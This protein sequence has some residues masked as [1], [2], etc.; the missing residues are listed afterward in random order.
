MLELILSELMQIET[1]RRNAERQVCHK[2]MRI[3]AEAKGR[4]DAYRT[5]ERRLLQL[6]DQVSRHPV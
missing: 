2:R 6:L 1:Y 4:A 5:V 3:A